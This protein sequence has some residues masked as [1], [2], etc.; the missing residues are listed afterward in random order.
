MTILRS[1]WLAT[2]G[3]GFAVATG[4]G[5]ERASEKPA[6]PP[7]DVQVETVETRD[8][9][10]YS[11]WVGTTTGF[12]NAQIRPK[13][14]GFLLRQRYK[15]GD[16]VKE[17]EVLFEIDPRQFQ[18]AFDQAVGDL[19][20]AEAALG[21]SE[22]DV[23]RYTPLAAQG[24]VS[25]Q[26]LDNA[27]QERAANMAQV[28]SAQ[29]A[30]QQARLNLDWTKVTSPVTGIAGIA[31]AQLGDLVGET[32]VLANVA[33]LDPIKVA[34]PIGENEYLRFAKRIAEGTRSA[35]RST[36]PPVELLLS[37]GEKY[38]RTGEV[39]VAGLEVSETTGTIT[40]QAY[41]PNPDYILR[42]GQ[43]ALVRLPTDSRK[44]AVVIRQRAV[45]ELQGLTQVA[46]VSPENVVGWRTVAL[47]PRT[48]S[49]W[50]VDSGLAGGETVVVEGLQKIRDGMKVA[51]TPWKAPSPATA[52][53]AEP[54]DGN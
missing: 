7:L 36:S 25:Q 40:I 50:I 53:A 52:K 12:V 41:F 13:V 19:K 11:E 26:E 3:V 29:A 34:F 8:V 51:P 10:L 30:L 1:R 27:I 47:G 31:I 5:C 6:P 45:N 42:P 43:Y 16:V 15:D 28:Y 35:D 46:V 44:G 33:Q 4:S 38:S 18:A 39:S 17:G 20:R 22:I 23:A 9:T 21:K 24:A 2:L 54:Q 49:D 48:G 32:T 14:Q 37:D